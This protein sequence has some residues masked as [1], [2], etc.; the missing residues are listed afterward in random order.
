MPMI[1]YTTALLDSI[2]YNYSIVLNEIVDSSHARISLAMLPFD[3]F[4]SHQRYKLD[5]LLNDYRRFTTE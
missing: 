2:P 4:S 5:E 1:D 3:T